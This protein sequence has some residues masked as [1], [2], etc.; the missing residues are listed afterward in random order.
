MSEKRVKYLHPSM[1]KL[2][3]TGHVEFSEWEGV[4]LFHPDD[5]FHER[6]LQWYGYDADAGL[7]TADATVTPL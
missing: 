6:L 7:E 4:E 5:E 1:P 3:M 2:P